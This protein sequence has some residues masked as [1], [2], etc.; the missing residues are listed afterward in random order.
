MHK[1]RKTY[2]NYIKLPLIDLHLVQRCLDHNGHKSMIH[3]GVYAE[4][5]VE[6]VEE[7]EKTIRQELKNRK[8]Y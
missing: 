7:T 4:H 2:I 1:L 8:D 3:V 5:G 6:I